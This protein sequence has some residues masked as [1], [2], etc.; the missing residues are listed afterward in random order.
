MDRESFQQRGKLSLEEKKFVAWVLAKE[1]KNIEQEQT[2]AIDKYNLNRSGIMRNRRT[3]YIRGAGSWM[4]GFLEI[5]IVKYLRF[6]DMRRDKMAGGYYTIMGNQ[7]EKATRK[8]RRQYHLYNRI[9]FGRMNAIAARLNVG[10]TEEIKQQLAQ[11]YEIP[12]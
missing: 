10:F 6:H 7:N 1:A 12:L 2:K 8:R 4:S 9:V 5:S 11:E 3:Y